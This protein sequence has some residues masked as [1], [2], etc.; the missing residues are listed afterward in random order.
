MAKFKIVVEL[1]ISLNGV[2]AQ[3]QADTLKSAI[4]HLA[5]DGI[6][7]GFTEAEIDEWDCEVSYD[8]TA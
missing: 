5:G 7:T 1:D 8:E 4:A 3:E 6:I 2:P